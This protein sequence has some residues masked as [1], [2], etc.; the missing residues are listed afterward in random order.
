[1]GGNGETQK[2]PE[3]NRETLRKIGKPGED[4]WGTWE[5][6]GKH[7]ET[8]GNMRT[9]GKREKTVGKL[10]KHWETWGTVGKHKETWGNMW[11]HGETLGKRV[12][13][14]EAR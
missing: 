1:M 12:E 5:I 6:M 3:K 14:G 4:I 11:T 9:T 13:I 10:V 2:N 8:W 7:R